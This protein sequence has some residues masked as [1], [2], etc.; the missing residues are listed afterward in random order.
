[1]GVEDAL[2]VGVKNRL[3]SAKSFLGSRAQRGTVEVQL[4]NLVEPALKLLEVYVVFFE[5]R[6]GVVICSLFLGDLAL[7][8]IALVEKLFVFLVAVRLQPSQNLLLLGSIQCD[9]FQDHRIRRN[10]S[11]PQSALSRRSSKQTTRTAPALW[12]ATST[13]DR[14]LMRRPNPPGAFTTRSSK[15]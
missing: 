15:V 3:A 1:M 4:F 5:F 14:Q 11:A 10:A 6:L 13:R 8:V 12:Q 9:R 7:E 2:G